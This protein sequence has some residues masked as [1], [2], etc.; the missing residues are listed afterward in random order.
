MTTA[1]TARTAP[2]PALRPRGAHATNATDRD[3]TR[4]RVLGVAERR[5]ALLGGSALLV[6]SVLSVSAVGLLDDVTAGS[7][8]VDPA[9]AFLAVAG[10][11]AV[12]GCALY[13]VLR[14]RAAAH[15]HAV[16]VSRVGYAVL[17]AWA[18]ALLLWRG[19]AGVG[20]FTDDWSDALLVLGIHLLTVAVALRRS[21][22]APTFVVLATAAAGAASLVEVALAWSG[23]APVGPALA[24]GGAGFAPLVAGQLVL[25][26]WLLWT[27]WRRSDASL[28]R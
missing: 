2:D 26:S 21:R 10:L 5:A 14:T 19:S 17:M 22:L 7:P 8:T 4:A 16:V 15:A 6:V 12:V 18:S 23:T 13:R 1:P 28:G 3:H 27:G 20:P 25:T 9:V 11:D 24:P